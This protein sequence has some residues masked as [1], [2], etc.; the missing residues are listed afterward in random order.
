MDTKTV[1][2]TIRIKG[3]YKE[4]FLVTED[5][6]ICFREELNSHFPF[7]DLILEDD[8]FVSFSKNDITSIRFKGIEDYEDIHTERWDR[9][10]LSDIGYNL[11]NS[12]DDLNKTMSGYLQKKLI[13]TKN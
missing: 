9:D 11:A 1:K 3:G 10:D 5:Y 4:E 8:E 7:I 2:I 13:N 6:A 12:L